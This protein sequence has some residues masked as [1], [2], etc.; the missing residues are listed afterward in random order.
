MQDKNKGKDFQSIW[1]KK[2]FLSSFLNSLVVKFSRWIISSETL[3][4]SE[5]EGSNE[6]KSP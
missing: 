5:K 6:K 4:T 3:Y 1:D 2:I